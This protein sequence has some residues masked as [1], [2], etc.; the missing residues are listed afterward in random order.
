MYYRNFY[1]FVIVTVIITITALDTNAQN[2]PANGSYIVSRQGT[3]GQLMPLY[4]RSQADVGPHTEVTTT[5]LLRGEFHAEDGIDGHVFDTGT[6]YI[7]TRTTTTAGQVTIA[8]QTFALDTVNTTAPGIAQTLQHSGDP[9]NRLDLLI[10]GE[11]YTA[12][13]QEKFDA[14]ANRLTDRFFS[15]SPYAEYRNYVNV[16]SLFLE[17]AQS[18]A[19]HPAYGAGCNDPVAQNDPA[20]GR[21]VETALDATYCANNVFRMLAVDTGKALAAAGAVPHWD[22]ILVVVNDPTYGGSGGAVGVLS[23]HPQ[24]VEIAQHEFGH[25]FTGLADTYETEYPGFPMCSDADADTNNNCEPNVTDHIHNVKWAAWINDGTLLPTPER[26][27]NAHLT[28]LFEGARYRTVGLY[29]PTYDSRM[30]NLGSP[31]SPVESEAYALRL[32]NG[33]ASSAGIDNI[34]VAYPLNNEPVTLA[35]GANLSFGAALL[36]PA[37][38]SLQVRWSV[39]GAVVQQIEAQSA[40][41]YNFHTMQPGRYTLKLEVTD[42]HPIIHPTNR[43]SASHEWQ[44]MV[45]A[46]ENNMVLFNPEQG[47]AAESVSYQEVEAE[48]IIA[49]DLPSPLTFTVHTGGSARNGSDYTVPPTLTLENPGGFTAGTYTVTL[50]V[51]VINDDRAEATETA[52]FTLLNDLTNVSGSYT[53]TLEDDDSI[54]EPVELTVTNDLDSTPVNPAFTWKHQTRT[55][56]TQVPASW[57]RLVVVRDGETYFDDWF[58]ATTICTGVTCTVTH[59]GDEYGLP[60]G[61]YQWWVVGYISEEN[62]PWAAGPA[63]TAAAPLPRQPF[64][65]MVAPNQG[66]PSITWMNDPAS[67]WYQIYMGNGE[68]QF[69]EWVEAAAI[70]DAEMCTVRPEVDWPAGT[71]QIWMQAWGPAGFSSPDGANTVASWVQARSLTLAGTP[72]ALP[73]ALS[74]AGVTNSNPVFTW[75]SGERS[76][77]YELVIAPADGSW[78]YPVWY[79]AG[80]ISCTHPGETCEVVD[81]AL[82]DALP[83]GDYTFSVR[84]WGPG[85]FSGMQ[86]SGYRSV[87]F[88]YIGG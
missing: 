37:G 4:Q 39:N 55:S 59:P 50:P 71:Y 29:R 53:L 57:Y 2:T 45:G 81:P 27:E 28:G 7:I 58:D 84:A 5:S 36:A 6:R 73:E 80:E 77:W 33:W 21:M 88:Q 15:I 41:S 51:T 24:T 19:D 63:F 79:Q 22:S 67:H 47:T 69:L 46:G 66:R 68:H 34:E 85:G 35:T 44:V 14:D 18:G 60:N 72:A 1:S 9:A 76:T 65:V 61:N 48:V 86:E 32:Y 16:H 52:T 13:E 11:G 43:M 26:P 31:F 62:M 78:S 20:A 74:V 64:G 23:T 82:K 8:G 17:S 38:S 49:A 40:T 87:T 56:E 54:M 83:A 25:S 75:V 12:A 42:V 30:R 3:N 70:C 10:I